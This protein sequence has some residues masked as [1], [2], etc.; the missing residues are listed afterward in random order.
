LFTPDERD[1]LRSRLT[2]ELEA[3]GE[4][5]S[6]ADLLSAPEQDQHVIQK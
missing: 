5:V 4:T 3:E 6:L 2:N 1:T